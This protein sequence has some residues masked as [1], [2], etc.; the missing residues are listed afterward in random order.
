MTRRLAAILTIGAVLTVVILALVIPRVV[1]YVHEVTCPEC[2]ISHPG[3]I[4]PTN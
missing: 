4:T 1:T 3:D 2:G